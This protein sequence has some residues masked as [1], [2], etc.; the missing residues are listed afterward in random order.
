[1]TNIFLPLSLINLKVKCWGPLCVV[2]RTVAL[3]E[4]GLERGL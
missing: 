3:C 4:Q 2:S 1:M